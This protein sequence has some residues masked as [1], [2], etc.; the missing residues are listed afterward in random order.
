[1]KDD[2]KVC[3]IPGVVALMGLFLVLGA[4]CSRSQPEDPDLVARVGRREIRVAEFQAWMRRR[5]VGTNLVQKRAL[6]DEVVGHH[7]AV[8]RALSL[9]L[10][11][12][13]KLQL[14]Y[15]NLLI[16]ALR[17]QEIESRISN[18]VPTPDQVRSWYETNRAAYSE[19]GMRRGAILYRELGPKASDARREEART[20]LLEARA[21]AMEALQDPGSIRGFGAL[22]VEYSEDAVTRYKG[23]DLGWLIEGRGD[24]RFHAVVSQTLFSLSP[25]N[26]I[27]G[28]L[29]APEGLYLVKLLEDRPM[30]T[31]PF[32]TV[33]D[34]I[35]HRIQMDQRKALETTW[36]NALLQG[37]AI[38][39]RTNRLEGIQPPSRRVEASTEPPALR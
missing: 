14:A 37:V 16:N 26:R 18:A 25:T 22:A 7:A 17:A 15:E 30:K 29:E 3:G 10:D 23:G 19:P 20:R 32:E 39:L 13:P 33:R 2:R 36:S 6:L 1:M 11:Q 24:N 21:K 28:I 8:E 31:K 38:D 27:S 4:G 12:D 5:G 34:A 35:F 9:G